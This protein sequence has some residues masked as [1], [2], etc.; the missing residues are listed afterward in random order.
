M[1]KKE[2]GTE[3]LDRLRE[4]ARQLGITGRM[5]ADDFEVAIAQAKGDSIVEPVKAEDL[6]GITSEEAK[7]IEVRLKFEDETREKFKRERQTKIDRATI[8]AEAE[9]LKIKI[10]L[11]ETPTELELAQ[12]RVKLGIQK[13]VP[14]PSP[15]TVGIETSK[16]GYYIFTNREQDDASHT[17]NLGGKY[18]I[19]LFPD[20]V[21]VLS[22]YHIRTWRRIAIVP[23][24]ERVSV[25]GPIVEGQMKE[26]CQ[27]TG[28]KQRFAFEYLGEAPQNA[29]FGLVTNTKILDGL[30]QKQLS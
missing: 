13:T 6:S 7:K 28:G 20:Q 18:V 12:A 16:R 21:H 17:V 1:D 10:D 22:E 2:N 15:E 27:R 11:P 29:Q 8:V 19:H 26:I 9:V 3:R 24:Y 5:T 4:E 23:V 30:K 14:K 25:P